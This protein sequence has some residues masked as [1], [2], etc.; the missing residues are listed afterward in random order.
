[1]ARA[2]A[3]VRVSDGR[4]VGFILKGSRGAMLPVE[5]GPAVP[6]QLG[7]SP[8]EGAGRRGRLPRRLAEMLEPANSG[9][10]PPRCDGR[11]SN[12]VASA[13]SPSPPRR[14]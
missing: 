11:V 13:R 9:I 2:E 3:A 10:L 14:G 1:M 7:V 6:D 8:G 12:L 4:W 5:Q